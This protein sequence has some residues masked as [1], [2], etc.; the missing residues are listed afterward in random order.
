[1]IQWPFDQAFFRRLE[2]L[3]LQSRR[4]FVGGARGERRSPRK[5]SGMEFVDFRPYVSGDDLH[6]VDWN[7]Y[8]RLNSLVLKLFI[9]EQDLCL[10]LLV[11]TSGSMAVGSPTKLEYALRTATALGYI[12][13]MNNEQVAFGFFHHTLYQAVPPRRGSGQIFQLLKLLVETK[14]EGRT[15]LQVALKRYAMESRTLGKAVLISDLLDPGTGYQDGVRSL[16]SHGFEVH[17]L[18]LLTEEELHPLIDGDVRLLDWEGRDEK[19]LTIDRHALA[20]YD[21]NLQRFCDEAKHFCGRYG[22]SYLRLTTGVP[23][24]DLIFHQ[25]RESRLLQ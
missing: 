17:L 16:V 20:R 11:D 8:S 12:A 6:Y 2:K 4:G 25:F 3:R 9:D 5:G 7:I 21:A 24:E 22:V 10:H 13:L 23:L 1:M 15:D 14:A 19:K 18:H